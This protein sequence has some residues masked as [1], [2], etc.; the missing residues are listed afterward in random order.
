MW[1]LVMDRCILGVEERRRLLDPEEDNEELVTDNAAREDELEDVEGE[2]SVIST[3]AEDLNESTLRFAPAT[4]KSLAA[5]FL[6]WPPALN[7]ST[8]ASDMPLHE[9]IKCILPK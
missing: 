4:A 3:S 9:L 6:D 1:L 2:S 8:S 7:S 5:R